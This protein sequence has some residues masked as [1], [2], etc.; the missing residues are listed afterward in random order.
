MSKFLLHIFVLFQ[1][2]L[3]QMIPS[4]AP[5]KKYFNVFVPLKY[6]LFILVRNWLST[7]EHLCKM[8]YLT[9]KGIQ[10]SKPSKSTVI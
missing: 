6:Y 1:D 3:T 4:V 8:V 7:Q 9:Y 5:F 2:Q 10:K